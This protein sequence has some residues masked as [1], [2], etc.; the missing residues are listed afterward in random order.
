VDPFGLTPD[1]GSYVP[2][3]ATER[4]LAELVAAVERP[5]PPAAILG[6]AGVGKTLLLHLLAERI[7]PGLPSVYL[8]NPRFTPEELCTWVARRIDAPA[9]E[10]PELFVRAWVGHLRELGQGCLLLVDDADAMPV[11]TARWLA[12]FAEESRGGL[13][14]VLAALAVPSAERSLR[15]FGEL[16]RVELDAAMSLAETVVYVRWR[17]AR[18]DVPEAARAR[19]DAGAIDELHRVAEGNPRRLHLAVESLVRGGSAA[20][21]EDEIAGHA[22]RPREPEVAAPAPAAIPAER[23]EPL[24]GEPARRVGRAAWR[25]LFRLAAGALALAA[26]LALASLLRPSAPAPPAA[27]LE[28][29]AQRVG[30]GTGQ[31]AEPERSAQPDA[32]AAL[33]PEPATVP[34]PD[35][36]P[37]APAASN[38]TLAV[39]LNAVPWARIE[40]DG[41]DLGE[42]PLANVP[43]RPGPH[44][45]R[46]EL[47]DGRIVERTI[48]IDAAHRHV[49]FE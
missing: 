8:P 41:I 43:L 21:L 37:T 29:V 5:G 12:A 9:A 47:P 27:A 20:V 26:A 4:V 11:P 31:P 28:G 2:R 38:G 23:G 16:R 30:P 49:V 14:L 17:L 1:T 46:A 7:G 33:E 36:A 32:P 19:F 13:R 22:A 25:P 6:A 40:V 44:A 48:E 18:A 24:R 42:T 35:A 34:A 39:H 10:E 3:E 45:F 15:A